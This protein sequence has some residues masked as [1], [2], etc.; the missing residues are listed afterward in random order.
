MKSEEAAKE[1]R[2][3]SMDMW[4]VLLARECSCIQQLSI[5]PPYRP[6]RVGQE[7]NVGKP[8]AVTPHARRETDEPQ[9]TKE[10]M[11]GLMRKLQENE[12]HDESVIQELHND[13]NLWES[14]RDKLAK[15]LV[16]QARHLSQSTS[17]NNLSPPP[18]QSAHVVRPNPLEQGASW[19]VCSSST[20]GAGRQSSFHAV[21]DEARLRRFLQAFCNPNESMDPSA[22]RGDPS[23]RS[24]TASASSSFTGNACGPRRFVFLRD[25]TPGGSDRRPQN[26]LAKMEVNVDTMSSCSTWSAFSRELSASMP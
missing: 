25:S 15:M 21:F 26:P 14:M 11:H 24:S 3:Q 8:K 7:E 18:P 16:R 4:D 23:A 22:L 9:S 13:R 19:S 1:N 2:L 20:A 5:P 6:A 17:R 10:K 12:R